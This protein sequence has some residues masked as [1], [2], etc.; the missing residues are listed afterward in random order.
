MSGKL[1]V[2]ADYLKQWNTDG[3]KVLIFSQTKKILNLIE[4][5]LKD[6]LKMSYSRMDGDVPMK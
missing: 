1:V 2:L 3:S 6:N 4:L 5:I